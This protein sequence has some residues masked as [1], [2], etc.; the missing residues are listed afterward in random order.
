MIR[1]DCGISK[2]ENRRRLRGDGSAYRTEPILSQ[3]K[4]Q[5]VFSRN[6]FGCQR[7]KLKI[8]SKRFIS[9]ISEKR[10]EQDAAKRGGK[11][12]VKLR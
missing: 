2:R 6:L 5:P 11:H 7:D 3:A 8:R 12:D 4:K 10:R 9:G 1:G